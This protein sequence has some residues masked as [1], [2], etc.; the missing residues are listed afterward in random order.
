LS[1]LNQFSD[2]DSM[3]PQVVLFQLNFVIFI[4]FPA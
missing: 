1:P 2:T 3:I 4:W